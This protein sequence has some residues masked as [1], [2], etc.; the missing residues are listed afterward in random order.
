[1][2][3]F[4]YYIGIVTCVVLVLW[5]FIRFFLGKNWMAKV[6][7]SL[8]TGKG[9]LKTSRKLIKELE[10]GNA[11]K[12]TL[13]D[14]SAQVFWRLT[15]TG[16]FG[17]IITCLPIWLL[18]QQNALITKQNDLFQFQN[19][20][21]DQQ[22]D[23][24]AIQ[25]DRIDLQN[26]LIEAERRS[27]LVFLMSNILDKVDDEIKEQRNSGIKTN[28][29]LSRPLIS[30]ISALSKNLQPYRIMEGDT[31]STLV[32]PERGQLF[33]A[34][35][36][37]KLDSVTTT[38]LAQKCDFSFAN[39]DDI[40]LEGSQLSRIDFE[41]ASL[42]G[43]NLRNTN[44]SMADFKSTDLSSAKFFNAEL[45][46]THFYK[47]NLDGSAFGLSNL[48]N[49]SF[50]QDQIN[51]AS[52][53]KAGLKYARFTKCTSK[54][55]DFKDANFSNAQLLFFDAK[56]TGF[57][58]A[59]FTDAKLLQSTFYYVN[60]ENA[61]FTNA[62]FAE[63]SF[64]ACH[65][66]GANFKGAKELTVEQLLEVGTLYQCKNLDSTL[67][68]ALKEQKPCLFEDPKGPNKC[69]EYGK[70]IFSTKE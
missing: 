43:A 44:L 58:G 37:N 29:A 6:G 67:Y 4:F 39:L 8:I 27:S 40:D 49:S 14:L 68:N 16:I 11:K 9:I 64:E 57:I 70:V 30:R 15:R 61:N 42:R 18:W 2:D 59:N 54:M 7:L 48:E 56:N 52:F 28:Y 63:S 45:G 69:K 31:L 32:S 33:I 26:N 25:N 53:Y 21:V 36:E 19:E 35:M 13:L 38:Q 10:G 46:S 23:L 34:L 65:M 17:L 60:F 24:L 20:K 12:E 41:H 62:N 22:T 47:S 5:V 51:R 3:Q 1:M 50:N 55:S 66:L